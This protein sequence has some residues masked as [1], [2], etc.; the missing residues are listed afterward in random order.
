MGVLAENG[1][2][3]HARQQISSKVERQRPSA[4]KKAMGELTA[5]DFILY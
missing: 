5:T 3:P 2:L 1:N 4:D